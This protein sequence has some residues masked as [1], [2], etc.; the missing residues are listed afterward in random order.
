[1]IEESSNPEWVNKLDLMLKE[2]KEK[3]KIMK[4]SQDTS[5]GKEDNS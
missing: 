2:I 3:E 4:S 1:M 5:D